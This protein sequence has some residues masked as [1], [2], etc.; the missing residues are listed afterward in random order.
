M[1]ILR[2]SSTLCAHDGAQGTMIKTLRGVRQFLNL[3]ST[4]YKVNLYGIDGLSL[5]LNRGLRGVVSKQDALI[6][7]EMYPPF[8]CKCTVAVVL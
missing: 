6:P 5:Q 1:C 3:A 7:C 2:L 4:Q 8:Y